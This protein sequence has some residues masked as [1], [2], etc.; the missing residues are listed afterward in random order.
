MLIPMLEV[1]SQ[2]LLGSTPKV[3]QSLPDD[4]WCGGHSRC[5]RVRGHNLYGGSDK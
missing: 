4:L 1:G 3:V 2:D 5:W